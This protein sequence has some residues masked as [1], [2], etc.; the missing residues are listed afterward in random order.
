MLNFW[1]RLFLQTP[2]E[3]LELLVFHS[4]AD[5]IYIDIYYRNCMDRM[6]YYCTAKASEACVDDDDDDFYCRVAI[7]G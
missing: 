4:L 2:F 5:V 6:E 3:I 1:L 7:D